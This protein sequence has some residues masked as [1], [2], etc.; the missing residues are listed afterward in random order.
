M[1]RLQPLVYGNISYAG[2]DIKTTP[3]AELARTLSILPKKTAS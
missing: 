1:A 2:K 3:T